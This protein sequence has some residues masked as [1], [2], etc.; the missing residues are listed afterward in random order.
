MYLYLE[1]TKTKWD[2]SMNNKKRAIP[3]PKILIKDQK[4]LARKEYFPTRLVIPATIFSAIFE[5][6]GYL[7]LNEYFRIMILIVQDSHLL[8]NYR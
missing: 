8:K 5:K 6:L 2:I 1:C 3:I 4:R 7:C